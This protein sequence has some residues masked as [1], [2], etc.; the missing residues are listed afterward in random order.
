MTT[1]RTSLFRTGHELFAPL[2]SLLV[3]LGLAG[4]CFSACGQESVAAAPAADIAPRR[5]VRT[6][7]VESSDSTTYT[8]PATVAARERAELAARIPATVRELPFEEGEA[9]RAGQVVARLADEAL[10]SALAAAEAESAVADSDRA[11]FA[12]LL[13]LAAAT[14]REAE[15]AAA[16]ATAAR[17]AVAASRDALVYAVLR[18]PFDGR[19]A[20]RLVHE[21]DVVSPGQ[22]LVELEGAERFELR[23]TIDGATAAALAAGDL[24]QTEVD[25]FGEPFI[26][27]VRAVSRAADPGTHRFEVVA[28]FDPP[29]AAIASGAY[30][31]LRLPTVGAN[32][33]QPELLIPAAAI[34]ERGGLVGVF[35]AEEGRSL[36]RWLAPGER[37]GD[38]LV[39]RSGLEAG[40]LVILDPAGLADGDPVSEEA[41]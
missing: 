9:V 18:A 26:V 13:E 33:P 2:P 8:A 25:G 29:P 12:R 37:R 14:P 30:A 19:L 11:R 38:R 1:F 39:V 32:P 6:A 4:V 31:R 41:L 3:L 23:A 27:R 7:V 5:A 40:E 35:V 20:R 21:G 36:L 15:A 16:R 10:R 34:V 17:A 22:P 28:D 24:L